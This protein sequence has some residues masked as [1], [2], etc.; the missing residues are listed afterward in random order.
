MA[1]D[2]AMQLYNSSKWRN[3]RQTIIHERGLRC[4]SCGRLV[5]DASELIADHIEELTPDNVHNADIALN[6]NNVQLL[7][8]D[9]HNA[10]HQRFGYTARN[11]YIIYGSP[12]SGKTTLVNQMKLRGDII[13]DMNM[14][15]FA[16]SGCSMY[17]KPDN[18]KNVVFRLRD[19]AI[20]AVRTR[21]GKWNNAFI[22]GGYPA[23]A[24][25]ESL[26]KKLGAE[27]IYCEATQEECLARAE[28]RGV[29]AS[30]YKKFICRWWEDFEP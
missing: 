16:I 6:Q 12:C 5:L 19:A 3:L 4:E 7:C 9:C 14:L 13:I 11:V 10:K 26:A 1:Q 17:D 28:L 23:K 2:W 27:L 22:V 18:I 30:E 15:Y 24:K 29:F 8:A 20:D 21:L 25:R